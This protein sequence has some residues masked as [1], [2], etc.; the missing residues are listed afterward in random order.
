M[1]RI[2]FV[3]GV[4]V[5]L[6]SITVMGIL[7]ISAMAQDT[8]DL[9]V[10][11]A[12]RYN[13]FYKDWDGQDAN[14]DKAGDMAFDTFR[15]NTDAEYRG[16]KMSAEYRFYSGYNMLH[17][18]Y[19]GYKFSDN[20]E[21]QLGVHQ[22][23]FGIQSYASHNW[24][25]G[26]PYYIGFEDDYDLGIKTIVSK[27]PMKLHLAFYKN[28]EGN[29]TGDS[30]DSARYSYDV[31][32]TDESELGYAGIEGT[33]ANEETNQFNA[34]LT[35]QWNHSETSNTEIGFSAE[36][37]QLYNSIT[38]DMG[39]HSA[40]AVHLNGT[41]GR[42]NLM[43]EGIYYEY[44][45]E[46]PEGQ[47]DKFVVMGAY[48]FPYKVAAEGMVYVVNLSYKV[49]INKGPIQAVTFYNDYSYLDKDDDDFEDSSQ[50]VL[51]FMVSANPLYIYFDIAGG[52]N[53][54]WLGPNYGSAFAEGN[55]DAEWE[56]RYNVNIGYYF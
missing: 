37:G 30:I 48:D 16:L 29:Y 51:G 7:P 14:N 56:F 49:P 31:V 44:C 5:I 28:D 2:H 55:P 15:L 20:T 23:P 9:H 18:G 11:G 33:R 45:P 19:V 46:N 26:I 12:L 13:L 38:E 53:Q 43:L 34:K 6:T 52:E 32:T 4:F 3:S 21:T 22:V 40:A 36:Y 17:H 25:F 47:S 10:G 8:W 39:D 1:K 41:Y 50:N 54:A 27:G 24:F 35:Y 42:F